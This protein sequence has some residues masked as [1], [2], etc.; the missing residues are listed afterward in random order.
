MA[1]FPSAEEMRKRILSIE[2]YDASGIA[3]NGISRYHEIL[4]RNIILSFFDAASWT[5]RRFAI[6]WKSPG[7]KT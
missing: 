4:E 3:A 7:K 6:S 2:C 5:L 1:V